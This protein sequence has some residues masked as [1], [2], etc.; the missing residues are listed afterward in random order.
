[1]SNYNSN[2]YWSKI[3][4]FIFQNKLTK[5][6]ANEGKAY[7]W[8]SH[9]IKIGWQYPED[10]KTWCDK[11]YKNILDECKKPHEMDLP[12][13]MIPPAPINGK[14]ITLFEDVVNIFKKEIEFRDNDFFL[15]VE[16]ARKKILDGFEIDNR[17]LENLRGC[18]FYSNTEYVCKAIERIFNM[19]RDR[20]SSTRV[21]ICCNFSETEQVYNFKITHLNSYSDKELKHPKI[22]SS[23]SGSFFILKRTLWSLCNF[24]IVSRFKDQDN[25]FVNARIEYLY[26]GMESNNWSPRI[27]PLTDKQPVEGFTFNLT[28]PV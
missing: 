2:L 28:F 25:N 26:D 5:L 1:M 4:P 16:T 17:N 3:F 22:L 7:E 11:H 10:L 14:T 6:Q 18:S 19:I 12:K 15:A 23:Q 27:T 24:S 21:K 9:K 20:G 8:G 13:N